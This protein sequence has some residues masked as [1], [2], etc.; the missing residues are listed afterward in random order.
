MQPGKIRRPNAIPHRT[1]YGLLGRCI[2]W[3]HHTLQVRFNFH[4]LWFRIRVRISRLFGNLL[5]VVSFV[6]FS[7][8]FDWFA[9][10]VFFSRWFRR[11]CSQKWNGSS[12]VLGTMYAYDIFAAMPCCPDRLTV[13]IIRWNRNYFPFVVHF[14]CE[15]FTNFCDVIVCAIRQKTELSSS[16]YGCNGIALLNTQ[17]QLLLYF[18]SAT[19]ALN[20]CFIHING[21][22]SSVT[23]VTWCH[24]FIVRPKI[25]TLWSHCRTAMFDN[26]RMHWLSGHSIRMPHWNH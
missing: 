8:H 1:L 21:W 16:Y 3:S 4:V 15:A 7:L 19:V 11:F 9:L 25:R 10:F 24:V 17:Q 5:A 26:R 6:R 23:I 22:T 13:S 20:F 2:K 12:L 18:C 14:V